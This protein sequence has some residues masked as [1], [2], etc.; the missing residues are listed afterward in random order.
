MKLLIDFGNSRCKWTIEDKTS[1]QLANAFAYCEEELTKR[2]GSIL[3][4][5]PLQQC[6]Q[7]HAVSVLGANFSKEFAARIA[8]TH[9]IK[10][11]FYSSQT[12]AFGIQLSYSDPSTYGADR[13]AA[14]VAAHHAAAGAKVVVDCG[15]AVTVD[16]ID[17]Q[18]VHRG[19]LILPAAEL[20]CAALIENTQEISS[21][22]AGHSVQYFNNNTQ[23]AIFSGSMLCLRHGLPSIIG[24]VKNLL[25]PDVSI[26]ITGGAADSLIDVNDAHYIVRP[27]L[28]LEGIAIMQRN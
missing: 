23:D 20:M 21:F 1:Q 9:D 19:G 18:G 11:K 12:Q 22:G 10:I 16:G 5:L 17:G 26:F 2:I 13:Y 3:Q 27:D 6:K 8:A 24:E 4:A 14:L 15:T 7:I 28:V 25:E